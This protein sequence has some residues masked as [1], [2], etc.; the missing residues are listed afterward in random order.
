ME[1]LPLSRII[2]RLFVCILIIF[3]SCYDGF[4]ALLYHRLFFISGVGRRVPSLVFAVL[5]CRRGSFVRT[6]GCTALAVLV[7]G[8]CGFGCACKAFCVCRSDAV[9]VGGRGLRRI[10]NGSGTVFAMAGGGG[11]RRAFDGGSGGYAEVG[12]A[13]RAVCGKGCGQ[14]RSDVRFAAVGLQTARMGGREQMADN[15]TCAP[16]RRGVEPARF[17]P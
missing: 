8:F 6:V 7:G 4:M 1:S 10:Q 15:G 13:A 16:R 12:R 5:G 9:R 3:K 14:R 17:E 11:F 2:L